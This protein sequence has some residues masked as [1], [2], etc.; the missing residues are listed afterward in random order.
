MIK[1]LANENV[2]SATIR[3]LQDAGYDV[4]SVSEKFPSVEDKAVI[5]FA[6]TEN[7]VIIT[8]DRDYGELIFKHGQRSAAGVIYFRIQSFSPEKSA[9]ILLRFLLHNDLQFEGYFTV[10]DENRIRQRK[11]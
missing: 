4:F 2:P 3:K 7:R 9:E 11:L 6:A 5:S 10:F 1:F 8:F